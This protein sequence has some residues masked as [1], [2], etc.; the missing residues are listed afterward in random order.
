MDFPLWLHNVCV[1]WMG[2]FHGHM[3]H[4]VLLRRR[5]SN[6]KSV[7]EVVVVLLWLHNVCVRWKGFF[8]G[9]MHH[10][11]LLHRRS[12]NLKS[13]AEVVVVKLWLTMCVFVG[14]VSSNVTYITRFFCVDGQ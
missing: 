14:R 3:H 6:P 8:Q 1:R 11:V 2:F 9:H 4:Q 13:V 7:V 5:S 12:S 10:Q